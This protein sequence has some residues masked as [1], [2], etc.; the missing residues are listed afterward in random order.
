MTRFLNDVNWDIT[1]VVE[2]QHYL[3]IKDIVH[4]T[5]KVEKQ[6]KRKG[7]VRLSGYLRSWLKVWILRD[8]VMHKQSQ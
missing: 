5:I 8:R 6:L 1:N 7:S 4:I 2:L 3:E